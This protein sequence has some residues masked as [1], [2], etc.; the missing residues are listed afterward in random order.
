MNFAV[1]SV[2]AGL[3]FVLF[4]NWLVRDRIDFLR[5]CCQ[6]RH[7]RAGTP[8]GRGHSAMVRDAPREA[9]RRFVYI[10]LA[11]VLKLIIC[12]VQNVSC[13]AFAIPRLE[14]QHRERC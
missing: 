3:I 10:G 7:W 2:V 9:E 11:S 6:N 13:L 14:S 1:F 8:K 4:R 12:A 5:R